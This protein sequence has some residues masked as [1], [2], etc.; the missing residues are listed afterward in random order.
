[1]AG[2]VFTGMHLTVEEI[3]SAGQKVVVR[4]TCN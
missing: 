4:F 1:M 2:K 3:V